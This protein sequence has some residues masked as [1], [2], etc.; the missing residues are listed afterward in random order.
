LPGSDVSQSNACD[1]PIAARAGCH[2]GRRQNVQEQLL[3]SSCRA[4]RIATSG[5][6]ISFTQR[7]PSSTTRAV[8]GCSSTCHGGLTSNYSTSPDLNIG[9]RRIG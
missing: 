7:Y 3:M 6:A 9:H 4:V 5:W 1:Y 8:V 2:T